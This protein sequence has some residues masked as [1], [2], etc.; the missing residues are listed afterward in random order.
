M[1]VLFG[2]ENLGKSDGLWWEKR[3][4]GTSRREEHWHL[5]LSQV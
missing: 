4:H 2:D 1:A 5:P 3:N